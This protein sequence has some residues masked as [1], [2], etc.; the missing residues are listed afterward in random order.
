MFRL[1]FIIYIDTTPNCTNGFSNQSINAINQSITTLFWYYSFKLKLV[2]PYLFH[3]QVYVHCRVLV[4]NITNTDLCNQDCFPRFRRDI[5][6]RNIRGFAEHKLSQ[7]P[8]FIT[9]DK[10]VESGKYKQGQ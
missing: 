7:G 3:F 8:L 4:C 1:D 2:S 10:P 9:K 5:S 6:G